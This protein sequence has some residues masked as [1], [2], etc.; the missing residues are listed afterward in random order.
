MDLGCGDESSYGD[1]DSDKSSE[2]E[3]KE[4][5]EDDENMIKT[6]NVYMDG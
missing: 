5:V 6:G 4:S 3:E 2:Q 1:E